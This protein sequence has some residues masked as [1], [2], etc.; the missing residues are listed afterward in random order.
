MDYQE[1]VNCVMSF[2]KEKKVCSSSRKSHGECY[3]S[4]G[5]YMQTTGKQFNEAK[6]MRIA[7]T[8]YPHLFAC[9]SS[10]F[11]ASVKR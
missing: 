5:E 3:A 7:L 6:T 10:I 8:I 4:L 11:N 2:L 1:T 9:R